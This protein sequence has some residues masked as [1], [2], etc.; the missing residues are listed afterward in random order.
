VLLAGTFGLL[1]R[2][3]TPGLRPAP[4]QAAG[5]TAQAGGPGTPATGKQP[6]QTAGAP[7]AQP[8]AFPVPTAPIVAAPQ[9]APPHPV[10]APVALLIPQ[11][12]VSTRLV[13]LGLT[14]QGAVQVPS[15]TTVG[16]WYTRSPR[17]GAVGPAIILGH[18]DSYRGPG[19]FFRLPALR[20]GDLVYVR[21]SDGSQVT[22]RVTGV[23]SYLKNEFPTQAVYGPTP[24]AELRLITCGGA[25]DAASGHYLSNIV[26][27]ATATGAKA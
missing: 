11:I 22:F 8:V 3:G 19:V 9:S 7:A 10:A 12:G 24:D 2:H 5:P 18:I 1:A 27:Y 25:F 26:V 20:P 4:A 13:T 16:G 14:A 15:S 6:A 17:P 23:Q 21:R